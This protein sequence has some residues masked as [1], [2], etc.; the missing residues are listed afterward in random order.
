MTVGCADKPCPR[1]CYILEI[2]Y[3]IK[4]FRQLIICGVNKNDP[5]NASLCRESKK[6]IRPCTVS[7]RALDA[8]DVWMPFFLPLAKSFIGT[9]KRGCLIG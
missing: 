2:V 6:K 3:T 8:V 5:I 1:R 4:N 9:H 7:Y